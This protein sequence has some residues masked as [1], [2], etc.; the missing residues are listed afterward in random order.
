MIGVWL[1]LPEVN[2]FLILDWFISL[3]RIR[4]T[5]SRGRLVSLAGMWIRAYIFG[6]KNMFDISHFSSTLRAIV[7]KAEN[8]FNQSVY[9]YC[10]LTQMNLFVYSAVCSQQTNGKSCSIE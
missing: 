8:D 4:A 5:R 7:A 1:D 10:S 9:E 3:E 2:L 6:A